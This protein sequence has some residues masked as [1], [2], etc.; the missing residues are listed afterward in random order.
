VRAEFLD[1]ALKENRFIPALL[2]A[3]QQG[4]I[5]RAEF[6]AGQVSKLRSIPGNPGAVVKR[7]FGE[8][9][10]SS[11]AEAITQYRPA[12]ELAGDAVKGKLVF[13]NLCASCHRLNGLGNSVGPD[14]ES[15]RATGKEALF[16]NILD[17]N[18]EVPPRFATYEIETNGGED[19]SGILANESAA[20]YTLKQAGGTEV[21][22]P[23]NQVKKFRSTG[24]SLMP[25]GLETDLTQQGLASLLAYILAQ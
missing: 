13:T 3:V 1:E 5:S 15:V 6:S 21:F 22:I 19:L 24:K 10:R 16:M 23:R 17:P 25:E 8:A 20:G 11:R 7:L 4:V 2:N 18:R 14:L 12:L 9:S